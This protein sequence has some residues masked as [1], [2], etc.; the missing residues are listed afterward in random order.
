MNQTDDRIL[1]ALD[2]SGMMLTPVVLAKNLDYSRSWISTRLSKLVDAEF[3]ENPESSFYQITDI[4]VQ[5]LEG[6]LDTDQL[7]DTQG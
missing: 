5:Y 1:E 4:G 6:E 2:E 3:V 7:N